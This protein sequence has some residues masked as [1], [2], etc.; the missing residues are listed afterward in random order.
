MSTSRCTKIVVRLYAL[1]IRASVANGAMTDL[2]E[3]KLFDAAGTPQ[4]YP[5][6]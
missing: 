1:R 6:L 2:V 4:S 3:M 5:L